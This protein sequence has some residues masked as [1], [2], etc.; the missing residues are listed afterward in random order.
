ME[1]RPSE[2]FGL[3]LLSLEIYGISGAEVGRRGKVEIRKIDI[4]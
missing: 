4:I 2:I 3:D 1:M